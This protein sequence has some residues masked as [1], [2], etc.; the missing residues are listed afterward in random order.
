MKIF[1]SLIL[2]SLILFVIGCDKKT[3]NSNESSDILSSLPKSWTI[4]EV[5]GDKGPTGLV[6]SCVS[7]RTDVVYDVVEFDY[8]VNGSYNNIKFH[9]NT[10]K[11]SVV[12]EGNKVMLTYSELRI[13]DSP[14]TPGSSTLA[15]C[16]TLDLN[17]VYDNNELKLTNIVLRNSKTNKVYNSDDFIDLISY[18]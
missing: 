7:A 3:V 15:F 18:R 5:L 10:D 13:G 14:S 16:Y 12:T 8:S 11:V 17:N 2:F 1:K 4:S 9:S 6:K